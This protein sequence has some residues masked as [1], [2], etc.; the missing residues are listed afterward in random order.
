MRSHKTPVHWPRFEATGSKTSWVE[1]VVCWT[2]L[3]AA[4]ENADP[5]SFLL[6]GPRVPKSPATRG[7]RRETLEVDHDLDLEGTLLCLASVPP[8]PM[9]AGLALV[10]PAGIGLD[11]FWLCF[12]FPGRL[13]ASSAVNERIPTT[14]WT[15]HREAG[16][17][18]K[19]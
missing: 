15:E 7:T 5:R 1:E 13:T 19:G 4:R 10:A 6:L 17:A 9:R 2:S 11:T 12:F 16:G 14:T 8:H 18:D 3:D